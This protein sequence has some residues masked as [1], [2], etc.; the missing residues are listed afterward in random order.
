MQCLFIAILALGT[1]GSS[2]KPQP[3]SDKT[4]AKAVQATGAQGKTTE[5]KQSA[6]ATLH[7]MSAE[8]EQR[9]H[10]MLP[11]VDDADLQAVLND[12]RLLIYTEREMPKAYQVWDGG[13][14][15]IHSPSYNISANGSEPFGNGNREFPWATP[16]GTHRTQG[17]EAFRFI[18]LPRDENDRPKPVVWFSKRLPGDSNTG[19]AWTFPVGAIVGEVLSMTGP[20]G[21]AYTFEVRT[22]TR[23]YGYWDV[24]VYRPFP[25]AAALA[26]KVKELRPDW[27]EKPNLV[28]A[29]SHLEEPVAMKPEHLK[30]SQPG[31]KTFDQWMGVDTLPDFDDPKLVSEL[32]S[33]TTFRSMTGEVWRTASN[34]WKVYAPSTEAKFQIVPAKYDAGFVQ[35]DRTS[36]MRC[37]DSV[38]QPVSL[39]NSG[40]DW[41][42]H[43]RGS[44]GIFSFHPF[45]PSCI[46][47]NGFGSGAKMRTDFEKA[48]IIAKYDAA[49]HTDT[50]YQS[51]DK[52]R[53]VSASM[54]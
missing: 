37:H 20:D 24:N 4:E 29:I 54:K 46:S 21:Y 45:D 2:D 15:G 18:W 17:V 41:Y 8:K 44:D 33:G 5:P 12:P 28:K 39:F 26:R 16:A 34:G 11:K 49:K 50:V 6:P 31:K 47:G 40:R 32:L 25:T 42:G 51:L 14:Q 36:C 1:S 30:D 7:L 13:L 19:Y 52:S 10:A 53:T 38:A 3:A 43:I 35:V 9:L 48:G 22:R 23:E 27:E